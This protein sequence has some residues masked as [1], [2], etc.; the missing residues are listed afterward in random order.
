MAY[1]DLLVVLDGD[2]QSRDRILVAAALAERFGA[3]LVGLY[4]MVSREPPGRFDYFNSDAPLFGPLYRDIEEKARAEAE[5]TR[6]LFEDIVGR[7][8]LSAEWRE[9]SG[10]P[11]EVAAMHGRYAD[12]IIVGQLDPKDPQAPLIRP[13]PEDVVLLAGRPI[14]VVPYAGTFEQIGQRV[15]VAW[16]ASREATRAVNDAIP[17]LVGASSVTVIAVEPRTATATSPE[18]T[19][20]STLP[21][22]ASRQ[23]STAPF[24]PA[25]ASATRCCRA[26]AISKPIS[27]SWALTGIRGCASWCSGV[28]REPC[29]PA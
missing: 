26:R 2:P 19:S 27:W 29:L 17:L 9:A 23:R 10:Y 15:L 28:P 8:S 25:S 22:T 16:D 11:A 18:R 6:I 4:V 20:H 12:L 1:K 7:Q 24:P 5:G 21:V 14:L 3:H 13:R